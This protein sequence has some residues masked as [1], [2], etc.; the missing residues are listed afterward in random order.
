MKHFKYGV[1]INL[2]DVAKTFHVQ[3]FFNDFKVVQDDVHIAICGVFSIS[4]GL[5]LAE[6]Y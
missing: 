1:S 4:W 5:A 3:G 2:W 6:S